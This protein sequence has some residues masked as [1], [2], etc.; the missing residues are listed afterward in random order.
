MSSGRGVKNH[1]GDVFKAGG[2]GKKKTGDITKKKFLKKK[3]FNKKIIKKI[4]ILK[5]KS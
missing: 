3:I 5:K 2:S 4:D 1:T